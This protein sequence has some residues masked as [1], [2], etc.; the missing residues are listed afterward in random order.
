MVDLRNSNKHFVGGVIFLVVGL[1]LLLDQIGIL[2][3]D[4][5]FMFWPLALIFFGYFR[6]THTS[7]LSGRFWGGFCFLLGISLQAEEFI[8]GHIR[9]DTVWPVL[10]ICAGILMILK[11]YESRSY[12]DHTPP[13][14]GPPPGPTVDVSPN[15]PPAGSVRS[16]VDS[17]VRS[18]V[19]SAVR[20][21]VHSAIGAPPPA[22]NT[23]PNPP[24]GPAS[25]S[26][27]EAAAAPPNPAGAP[28]S[29]FSFP[30]SS[31]C[32]PAP[33]RANFSGDSAGHQWPG[34]DKPWS[35]F[36]QNMRDFGR[37]MD[38]FGERVH[39]QWN[40]PGPASGGPRYSG[41]YS[42]TGSPRLN[43]VNI[44]WGGKRR[45]LSKN[46]VGG[47]IIAIFG[48][49]EIDLTDS[50]M[51]G[52]EIQIDVVC[53]FGGGEIR[54]PRNWEVVMDTVGIFGGCGDRTHHPERPAPGATNPDGSPVP[55]PKRVILKGVAIF[56]G[57]GIKN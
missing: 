8:Y 28:G 37:R 46:F 5:I 1:I 16:A 25:E 17:S 45:I 27:Q 49:Y 19:G 24:A 4:R 18:A 29:S 7:T 42:E 44:F 2:Q 38:E 9:F 41:N 26:A 36:E 6:F 20:S 30:G 22:S 48:G 13:E 56:G 32:G 40:N 52:D 57:V 39:K 10:L 15:P 34:R 21:A 31:F 55:Q 3:A 11:R 53:I 51:A 23:P 47:E 43:E 50:E 14:A 12:T 33:P 35:E 54:V